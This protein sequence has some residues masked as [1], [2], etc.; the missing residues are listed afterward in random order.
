MPPGK[1][2]LKVLVSD[3]EKN[4]REAVAEIFSEAGYAV[5]SAGSGS[6]TI[7]SLT[8]DS[9]DLIL[10]DIDMPRTSGSEIVR[11]ARAL[12]EQ[13]KIIVISSSGGASLRTRMKGEGA[14]AVLTKPLRKAALLDIACTA[15]KGPAFKG[16]PRKVRQKH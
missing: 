14:F 4:T 8:R 6:K 3:S 9:Y 11:M 10:C 5:A 13:A 16:S 15:L 2:K 1:A 7:E 12:N